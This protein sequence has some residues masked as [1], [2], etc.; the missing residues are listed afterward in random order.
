MAERV[1]AIDK[2]PKTKQ[3]CSNICNQKPGFNSSGCPAEILL[4]LQRTAGNQAVQ[5]LIKSGALQKKH[6]M[7]KVDD[8]CRNEIDQEFTPTIG[9]S[10][11][12]SKRQLQ[13]DKGIKESDP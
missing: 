2:K 13:E 4:N 6:R 10:K 9:I 7:D 1:T 8:S 5:K 11:L 3:K 12:N